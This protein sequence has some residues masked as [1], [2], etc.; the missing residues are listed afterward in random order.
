MRAGATGLSVHG[1]ANLVLGFENVARRGTT[2]SIDAHVDIVLTA[3]S[4]S[5]KSSFEAAPTN[6]PGQTKDDRS[7]IVYLSWQNWC[8][9]GLVTA[10]TT[11]GDG[12]TVVQRLGTAG[13]YTPGCSDPEAPAQLALTRADISEVA[14]PSPRRTHQG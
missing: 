5:V 2:C 10:T 11:F 12:T 9:T 3:G 4:D 13:F 6:I 1:P 8:A 14:T 7:A